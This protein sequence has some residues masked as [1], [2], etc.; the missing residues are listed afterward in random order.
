MNDVESHIRPDHA[1]AGPPLLYS[2]EKLATAWKVSKT[3]IRKWIREGRLKPVRLCRRVLIS[4]EEAE[5]FCK[6]SM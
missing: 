2:V 4:Q 1:N 6:Q 3:S 5:R